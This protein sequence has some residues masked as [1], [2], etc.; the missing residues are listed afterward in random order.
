MVNTHVPKMLPFKIVSVASMLLCHED[1]QTISPSAETR[2]RFSQL[3][4]VCLRPN[5]ICTQGVCGGPGYCPFQADANW[6]LGIC[7]G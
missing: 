7:G 1:A 4:H 5:A 6:T 3:Q 2:T